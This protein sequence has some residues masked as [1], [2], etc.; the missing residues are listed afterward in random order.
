[1]GPSESLV[2]GAGGSRAPPAEPT[3]APLRFGPARR[4]WPTFGAVA[5]TTSKSLGPAATA[6]SVDPAPDPSART[7]LVGRRRDLARL[8][9]ALAHA[10]LVTVTGPAGVGKSRLVR[11]WAKRAAGT[12]AGGRA[13]LGPVALIDLEAV[14]DPELV[15]GVVAA[16]LGQPAGRGGQAELARALAGTRT[17][18]VLDGCDGLA[19]AIGAL[20]GFLLPACPGL[21]VLVTS[22]AVLHLGGEH[23]LRLDPLAVPEPDPW[24]G[25]V[26][27]LMG[28]EAARLFVALARLARPDLELDRAGARAVARICRQVGG[29]PLALELVAP[30]A[31][32]LPL[33]R[34]ADALEEATADPAA[35]PGGIARPSDLDA[36]LGWS[37][38]S[39]TAGERQV[40]E[41]LAVFPGGS[42]AEALVAVSGSAGT[43]RAELIAALCAL[44]DKSVVALSATTGAARYD[45]LGVL[46]QS[47]RADLARTGRL[48]PLARRQLGWFSAWAAGAEEAL[49]S[50]SAQMGWL[51]LLASEETNLRA[52]LGFALGAGDA[53]AAAGLARSLWRYWE[54]RGALSEG[55]HWL[56]RVL[57]MDRVPA[58]HRAHLLDGLGMLAWRQGDLGPA[59]TALE[60]AAD[61]AG[62]CGEALLGAR[63][64]NHLGLVALFG[65]RSGPARELFERSRADLARLD[66]PGEAALAAANLGLVAVEEGRLVDAC[67]LLDAAVAVQVALGDRHGE[68]IS[69]L[70]RSIAQ[71]YLGDGSCCLEEARHAAGVF[72]ELGDERSLGFA[73]LV[74]ACVLA[75]E[76]PSLS[77]EIFGLAAAVQERIGVCP[78]PGWMER[79]DAA[80]APARAAL[81]AAWDALMRRGAAMEPAD[82]LARSGAEGLAGPPDPGGEPW[83]SVETLGRFR[84]CRHGRPV[85]LAP[86]AARLVKLVAAGRGAAHVE[87]VMESLWPEVDPDVGRRRLRN[88]LAR[89]HREAG[90]VVVREDQ[91]LVLADG[92]A[93]DAQAFETEARQA[94]LA[95]TGGDHG[96]AARGR[97]RAAARLYRG[98]FLA[99]ERYEPWASAPRE[100]LARIR[101]RLLDAWAHAAAQA[102]EP[103]EAEAC[104]RVAIEADPTDEGRYLGLAR[105]LAGSE[106]PAAAAAVLARARAM[107]EELGVRPS[108]ALEELDRT[109]SV[110]SGRS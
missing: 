92:V 43:G 82:A 56:G 44:V 107:A 22:Q 10:R 23:V 42:A 80:L 68:A 54:L 105:L 59:E 16:A 110:G 79:V 108:P 57:A 27:A 30:G 20:A 63:V 64:L 102:G 100:R 11:E 18:L 84:V 6:T 21:R 31:R 26:D 91:A 19:D 4:A 55:R 81:G 39:L 96:P 74:V 65:G 87:Q 97:A 38:G 33:D 72:L 13:G 7:A 75:G 34:L 37:L 45:L 1:M 29:L 109:M 58:R 61:L 94:V 52:A 62:R 99:E 12:P 5:G 86:Q 9:E 70:H 93:M 78:P 88:V 48:E 73:L 103:A 76:R 67:R 49:I 95:L 83:A 101:L 60:E 3:A 24:S 71:Y 8:A 89:L 14:S 77:V 25:E 98:D 36:A 46:R 104:W 40:L 2:P 35:P 90:P 41:A 66:A 15:A 28:F 85:R 106:R 53:E 50:G 69:R 32:R 51:G 47:L 17:T